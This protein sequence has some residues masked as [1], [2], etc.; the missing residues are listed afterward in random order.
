MSRFRRA[1]CLL[2]LLLLPA[3]TRARTVSSGQCSEAPAFY[4][5]EGYSVHDVRVET[6]LDWLLKSVDQRLTAILSDPAVPLRKGDIYRKADSDATFIRLKNTF[7]ELTVDPLDRVAV[8]IATPA[9]E[10][11]DEQSKTVDVVFH[12]YTFSVSYYVSRIFESA[13]K[14]Q[15][16][17]SVVATAA[18][19]RLADYFP[20][21][22]AGYNGSRGLFG[23]T[24]LSVRRPGGFLDKIYLQASG[25][26]SSSAVEAEASGS[27][28]DDV[29][30]FRHLDYR[31]GY[32]Y[33]DIRG[34]AVGLKESSG[35]L[36][37][38]G[39]SR[40]MG[41]AELLVRFG[42]LL[43][44]GNKDAGVA[45][46]Q[47]AAGD[48]AQGGY[49]SLK[50]FAGGTMRAGRHALKASYGL[51][52]GYVGNGGGLAYVKQVVD[53]AA[54]LRFLPK[55]HRPA[56]ADLHLTAGSIH[57]RGQLLV[58]ERFFGGN[59][60]SNFIAGD[61]WIIRSNPFIRSFSQNR[62]AR[63]SST[64]LPGGDRFVSANVTLA[65][66]VW[67]RPLVPEEILDEP[68][69][70]GL[71][72]FEF[73]AAE[74]ALRNEYLSGTVEFR[75]MAELVT[76]VVDALE[77]V[78]VELD[79]LDS[80]N[81]GQEIRDQTSLCRTDLALAQ[82][83][84]EAIRADLAGGQ[85]KTADIRK[86]V[87]GF[88]NKKPPI[89]AYVSDLEDDLTA[90]RDLPGV[91]APDRLT[92]EIA[93]LESAR[94]R[95]ATAFLALDESPV[96]RQAKEKAERDMRLPRR[97]FDQLTREANLVGV[98]PVA[99]FDA[100]RLWQD[101][102]SP[103]GFRYA[104]GGGLRLSIVSVDVTAV[105]AWNP[106]PHAGESHGALLVSMELSNLFR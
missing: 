18:T 96:A 104:V 68:D 61:D 80:R 21:P 7:P 93:D 83:T 45:P 51:E 87:V 36:Q 77:A 57:K 65:P 14:D 59:T 69:F 88:P 82:G 74:A 84:S 100:A 75:A 99:V 40:S 50:T 102:S 25:S 60:E 11:C 70:P 54:N 63:A 52:L 90:L 66:T 55:D 42:G 24:R 15:L 76:P 4:E 39:A 85:P 33:S 81:P 8:R 97:V 89:T 91:P 3:S 17:R 27:R 46:A 72:E 12:V 22:F 67:A 13:S 92:R 94:Q 106:N 30:F 37:L 10:N 31:L 29:G 20:Q 49:G 9:L 58:G 73:S 43:E 56:T 6:P 34:G 38:A 47:V 32:R 95:M 53:A 78:E 48:V 64:G 71:A 1:L 86:L 26:A 62:F 101:G 23:G 98:S 105:Y 44:G 2:C 103:D 28:E 79:K 5:R 16:K 19:E 35:L 41:D